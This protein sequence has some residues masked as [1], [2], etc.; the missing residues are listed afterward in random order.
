MNLRSNKPVKRKKQKDSNLLLLTV[1]YA[2]IVGASFF[3]VF[4]YTVYIDGQSEK[5]NKD[6]ALK[7]QQI[8]R[9]QR[10]IQNLKIKF[11]N[12]SRKDYIVSKISGY[13]LELRTPGDYQVVNLTSGKF[14]AEIPTGSEVAYN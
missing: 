14:Y 6:I 13:G 10:E 1:V 11:E 12:Y 3:S 4:L 8:Y 9:F 7:D 2:L 5:I